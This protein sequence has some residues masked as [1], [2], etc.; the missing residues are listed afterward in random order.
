MIK[1]SPSILLSSTQQ[2]TRIE[3]LEQ[4]LAE[5][6]KLNKR[7][8]HYHQLF[9][10][11]NHEVH[12]WQLVYDEHGNIKTWRLLDANKL[13]LNTWNKKLDDI[14]G[15]TTDEIF[16]SNA[17]ETFLPI[18]E[19]IFLEQSNYEWETYFESTQQ[20]LQMTSIPCGDYFISTGLDI[21]AIKKTQ[22]VL[23]D[24][25][26]KLKEAISAGNIGLWDWDLTSNIVFYSPEWKRQLGYEDSEILNDYNEWRSRVHPDDME[27]SLKKI[28]R[29]LE[30]H[31]DTHEIEFRMLHK[32][33]SYR[34]ILS[35]VSSLRNES[36]KPIRML[37]SHI[38]ITE[39]K[40]MEETVLQQQKMQ[41][42][43]TLAGGIAHD[44]NNLLTPMLGYSQLIKLFLAGNEKQIKYV[45]LIEES[46]KRAKDLV[47]KILIMSR[48]SIDNLEV[49]KLDKLVEEVVTLLAVSANKEVRIKHHI[50]LPLPTIAADP[51]QIYQ[52]VLNLCTNAIQA[53]P[54][55]GELNITLSSTLKRLNNEHDAEP[56]HYVCLSVIDSGKGFDGKIKERIFEP[57]FT[58][59]LQGEERG[60]G[61][62]LSI[63]ASVIKQH[64]G[65]IEVDSQLGKGTEFRVYFPVVL[66]RSKK[67]E[68][69]AEL[70]L[71][72]G[73][74]TILFIDDEQ[75]LCE[76]GVSLLETLG[77]RV[78][79]FHSAKQAI[80]Y[81]N[82]HHNSINLI[83][84]DYAMPEMN[85]PLVVEKLKQIDQDVPIIMVTG[86]TNMVNEEHRLQWGCD[87]IMSK[88]YNINELS[89]M[90]D[91]HVK[92][93]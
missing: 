14:I 63:V 60:S 79:A 52:V 67:S 65:Y 21:T 91:K 88:P 76:L 12:V 40:R 66:G 78:F 3:E 23:Q 31:T 44:F 1:Q 11:M 9:A 5:A 32:D 49:V 83:I 28:N 73:T 30:G 71:N 70:I 90:I 80:D 8:E 29:T 62:G 54:N 19:K 48:K 53:M 50:S 47:E 56:R 72:S 34:W 15:L 22:H 36:G 51:S 55:G 74:S 58:T 6:N 93:L 26:L 2:V 25:L 89:Q 4:A 86:F 27:S 68:I 57:F 85:G 33:G 35:H 17:T 84:T 59:K 45:N 69:K 7:N 81:F 75:S 43:G 42:L 92:G 46:A 64:N 37:G 16:E 39:R 24:T 13:A 10:N 87:A 77:Y 20:Y 38:D 82:T 61:L 18:V 41:A